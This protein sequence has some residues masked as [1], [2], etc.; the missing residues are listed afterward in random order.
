MRTGFSTG[1]CAAAAAKASAIF[2]SSGEI[3]DFVT[4]K[5]LEGLEFLLKVN[6]EENNS[7]YVIKDSGD[8]K[9]DITNG[10]KIFAS[11]TI[12]PE[13]QDKIFFEAGEGVGVV[14]LPG[15]KIPVG[16]PAI[17]PVP[18]KMIELA[19]R[20]IIPRKSLLVKISIPGGQEIAP[21]TFNPRLGIKNGLSVLG[22]S[23]IVKPMDEKALLDSLSLELNMIKSLNFHE[24]Y[25]TFG[26]ESEKFARKIFC[27]TAR[28][29]IQAEN[30]IG[31]VL[32]EAAR[33]NFQRVIIC[34][35]AG[36][37]LKVAAGAFN[38]HNKIS[39]GRREVL[40]T[41]L[42]LA[43]A[44]RELIQKIFNSNTTQEAAEIISSENF[45]H[46][47]NDIARE[48]SIRCS[49]RTRNEIKIDVAIINLKG[50]VLGRFFE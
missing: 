38:T 26:H 29:V 4:I 2:L 42:A 22:T 20:E 5:N 14:T 12:L 44:K 33:L 9:S 39:D 50:E 46:V 15:L 24:L 36:K 37:L 34:G 47:W 32:D 1:A 19:V 41:H 28:N 10:L 13:G 35:H 23:G 17:N 45:N 3:P 49:T 40:C 18:R 25:I 30:Y 11:V 7:F 43:G 48:I 31:Y 16:Q 8:D 21:F 27:V 6:Q